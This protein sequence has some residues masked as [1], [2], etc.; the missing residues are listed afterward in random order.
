M[1][2]FKDERLVKMSK[3]HNVAQ[4]VSFSSGA[5][6][7][8]RHGFIRGQ[9]VVPDSDDIR[10]PIEMLLSGSAGSVNVR[11]FRPSR[12]KGNPFEYGI[13]K[14]DEAIAVV[15]ALAA[16]GYFTMVNETINTGDGGVSGVVLGEVMEFAPLDTPR[17]V[18]KP[19]AV[20][21]PYKLGMDLLSTVYGFRPEITA[22]AGERLEFSIH[23]L[24]VG[25]RH[26][27]TVLWEVEQVPSVRLTASIFW[28]NRFSQFI[29]DKAYGLLIAY[30]L[31]LPVPAT[32]VVPRMV[33]PFR[34]GRSTGTS[35]IWM[36][37]APAVQKPG[38]FPTTFGWVDPYTLLSREDPDASALPSVL[39]Q[40]GVD[41]VY[42]GASLPGETVGT[43]YIEG[44]AGRGDMFMLGQQ[45][46]EALPP[47]VVNDVR[48]LAT[49]ASRVL[50]PVRVEFA[51]DGRRAWV[52][53]LHL[54]AQQHRSGVISPGEPDA[55][56]IDFHPEAGLDALNELIEHATATGQGIRV[57]GQVGL[58][59]HVGDLLRKS[60]VPA[61]LRL[62]SE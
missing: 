62:R 13:T 32:T 59:S 44:V 5:T 11:S 55:G 23:P 25:Y 10:T 6:P 8:V 37:T 40:E 15:R 7:R 29:G 30:L 26:T 53:Q 24:R 31:D 52:V 19:G 34:F 27:H 41:A 60:Q 50:G 3:R 21:L 58:T 28:P 38:Y 17:G 18:E 57:V 48:D 56:W 49:Q 2:E 35:E 39:A 4:F 51:H 22:R 45:Q 43:D 14:I 9:T 33:A 42:S 16:D 54:A 1:R 20:S 47:A 61:Q 36:R 46:P 12:E